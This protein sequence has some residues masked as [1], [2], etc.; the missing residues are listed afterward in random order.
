MGSSSTILDDLRRIGMFKRDRLSGSPSDNALSKAPT[1]MVSR[2]TVGAWLRGRRLPQRLEPLL[3]IVGRIRVEAASRGLLHERVDGSSGETAEELLDESRWM[4]RWEAEQRVRVR[5]VRGGAERHLARRALEE[6]ERRARQAALADRPRPVR[7]WSQQRLGVHPAI[8]GRGVAVTGFVLPTFV[9]RPQD[10]QMHEDV[11]AACAEGVSPQF[12]VVCGAS[13]T[14]KTRTACE[15]LA[16]VPDDFALIYPADAEGLLAALAADALGPRTVLWLNEAHRYFDGPL[17]DAVAAALLRRLDG[18]G[19]FLVIATLWPDQIEALTTRP[20]SPEQESPH[21]NAK[22]LFRQACRIDMPLSF[23][24]DF[25][26]VRRAA[27]EDASLAAALES[28]G[29][30]LTQVL[31]AGPDLVR[32]YEQPAGEHGIYGSALMAVA[33]DAHRLGLPYLPLPFLEAAAPGYLSDRQ[34]SQASPDW[35]TGALDYARALIKD[36][37]RPLQEV[38]R[39]S[40]MGPLPGVLRLADFLQQHGRWTRWARCPPRSFWEAA[41]VHLTSGADLAKFADA[42]WARGRLRYASLLYSAAVRAGSPEAR[43]VLARARCIDP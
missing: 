22:D 39:P 27:V 9:P 26:A 24:D 36:T 33:M 10:A 13:C 17:G 29:E 4:A 18:D 16:A 1:P 41:A 19:L 28:G 43:V 8:S 37:T 11:F 6:E 34:R 12:V 14:G 25:D 35:F 32:H 5:A 2:D 7:V 31:A 30:C 23:A 38:P 42:A 40:G 3:V 21:R 15:A 20:L